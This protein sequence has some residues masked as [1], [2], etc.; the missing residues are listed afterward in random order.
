MKQT[1]RAFAVGLCTAAI[2]M[3]VVSYFSDGSSQNLSDMPIEEVL[4]HVKEQGYHVLS[5]ED[6]ISL[7]MN[8]KVEKEE[9]ENS[10][11]SEEANEN[12]NENKKEEASEKEKS[13][14]SASDSDESSSE[15]S[16]NNEPEEEQE[17]AVKSYTL[18]IESGM[19][20]STI[21][22]QLEENG[23]IDN[24]RDF[25]NYLEDKGYAK[26]VQLGEFTLTSDMSHYEIAEALTR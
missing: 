5:E 10:S 7:S 9:T 4:K 14:E 26:R 19:P 3:L 17:E 1:I 25:S 8:H 20:S 2:I 16:S 21:S 24:A 13:D 15:E 23:I 12:E 22:N 6:Y 11:E 18:T